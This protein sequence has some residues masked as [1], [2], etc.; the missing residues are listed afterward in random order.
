[1]VALLNHK[2]FRCKVA[3]N[4]FTQKSVAEKLDIAE[5]YVRNLCTKD[6]NVSISLYYDICKTFE[7]PFDELL[8]VTD[9]IPA[10]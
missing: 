6:I 9:E 2:K 10:L 1:M 8:V 4:G 5:R 7:V 3:E